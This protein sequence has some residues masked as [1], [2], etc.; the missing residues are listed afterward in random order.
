MNGWVS[1]LLPLA[2]PIVLLVLGLVVVLLL[3]NTV[4]LRKPR[5]ISLICALVISGFV[6]WVGFVRTSSD[7][8]YFKLL[9]LRNQRYPTPESVLIELDRLEDMGTLDQY[10]MDEIEQKLAGNTSFYFWKSRRHP[11]NPLR[12]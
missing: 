11:S 7:Q 3:Q 5:V 9:R 4:R 6:L 1:D 2:D 8:N 12:S 10:T